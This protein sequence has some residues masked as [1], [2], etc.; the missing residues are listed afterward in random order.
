MNRR[1][2]EEAAERWVRSVLDRRAVGAGDDADLKDWQAAW[3]ALEL[4]QPAAPLAPPGFARRV[5]RARES[6]LASASAPILGA[7]WMRAAA[8]AAL[9]AGL[10]LGSTLSLAGGSSGESSAA[11]DESWQTTLLSEEYLSALASPEVIL[12]SPADDGESAGAAPA[13]QAGEP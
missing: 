9:L 3:A 4:P 13:A 11:G 6:E 5:A 2:E 8:L 7:Y 10:A 12:A 1:E